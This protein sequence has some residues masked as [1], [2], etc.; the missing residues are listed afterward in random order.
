MEYPMPMTRKFRAKVSRL[1]VIE[2][3]ETGRHGDFRIRPLRYR[4][5]GL[6]TRLKASA[7]ASS[8]AKRQRMLS[9]PHLGKGEELDVHLDHVFAGAGFGGQV[10]ELFAHQ[11]DLFLQPRE[12]PGMD[13]DGDG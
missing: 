11:L 2:H 6:R 5:G 12:I 3:E 7:T 8:H 10:E 1:H 4:R 13:G 9:D